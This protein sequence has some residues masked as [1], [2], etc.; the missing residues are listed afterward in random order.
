MDGIKGTK[1]NLETAIA[2]EGYEYQEM[3]PT[4]LA[5]AEEENERRAAISFGH[6]LPVEEG[7]YGLYREAL[8]AVQA[9][10]DLPEQ[11]AFICS[12]CG[13]TVWGEAPDRCPVCGATREKFV[14]IK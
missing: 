7:H 8:K 9:G 4:F 12:V 6:A 1:E 10:K 14:E 3:Y 2:G 5:Q 13:H 11:Q